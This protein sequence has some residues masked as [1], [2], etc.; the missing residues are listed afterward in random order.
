[1][2]TKTI[3]VFITTSC[4][5]VHTTHVHKHIRAR[6]CLSHTRIWMYTQHTLMM[7]TPL[8]AYI[9]RMHTHI[10]YMHMHTAQ[11]HMYIYTCTYIY[12]Q[13]PHTCMHAHLHAHTYAQRIHAYT[14]ACVHTHYKEVSFCNT[15][16]TH[17]SW[18]TLSRRR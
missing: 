11:S 14:Y 17:C 8:H 4:E 16:T 7:H 2:I 5:C 13:T 1:M 12:T 6:M 9:P 10:T 15:C 3:S 18:R